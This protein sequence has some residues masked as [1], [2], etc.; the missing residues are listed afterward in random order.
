MFPFI[1]SVLMYA[2]TME[3]YW[4]PV[5]TIRVSR[6]L[7]SENRRLSKPLMTFTQVI[8]WICLKKDLMFVFFLVDIR[9]VRWSPSGDMLAS[10]SSDPAVKLLDFKA[11]K[12]LYTGNTS[13]GG[14]LPISECMIVI[15]KSYRRQLFSMLH[16]D[17]H[18]A[19]RIQRTRI[20]LKNA[21]QVAQ[22]R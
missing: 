21:D 6:Y 3:I 9:C 4:L 1:P 14:K 20:I 15:Q 17:K 12:A 19:T 2:K 7:I 5:G 13:D 8:I 22:F 16:L 11:G 10:A 18:E